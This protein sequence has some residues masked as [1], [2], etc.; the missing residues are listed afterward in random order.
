MEAQCKHK[1]ITIALETANYAR[2][3]ATISSIKC[4]KNGIKTS[5][6]NTKVM[7]C[8]QASGYAGVKGTA[9]IK[10]TNKIGSLG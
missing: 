6:R 8:R 1:V 3:Y 10:C 7:S 2:R 5:T 9:D 4:H